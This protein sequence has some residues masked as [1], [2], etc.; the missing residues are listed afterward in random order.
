MTNLPIIAHEILG[1]YHFGNPICNDKMKVKFDFINCSFILVNAFHALELKVHN[2][3]RK[4]F[5]GTQSVK[6]N[7]LFLDYILNINILI[8]G[9]S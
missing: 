9:V 7:I 1:V 6:T 3:L 4:T 8:Q 5:I 2:T